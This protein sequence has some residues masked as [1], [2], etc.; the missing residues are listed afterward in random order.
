MS[1]NMSQKDKVQWRSFLCAKQNIIK[2]IE[3]DC[4]KCAN[5]MTYK[6]INLDIGLPIH[7]P[8]DYHT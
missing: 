4:Q 5:A 8:L 3:K 6:N 2:Y 7:T 1:T